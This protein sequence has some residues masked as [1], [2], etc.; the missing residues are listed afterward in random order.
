MSLEGCGAL[1]KELSLSGLLFPHPDMG[2]ACETRDE[3]CGG[4]D[5]S[6]RLEALVNTS[7]ATGMVGLADGAGFPGGGPRGAEAAWGT[8]WRQPHGLGGR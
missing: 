7:V 8:C 2:A 1:G 4:L 5:A 6:G 3:W